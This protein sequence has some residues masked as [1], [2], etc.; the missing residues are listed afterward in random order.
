MKTKKKGAIILV[1][2]Q[3]EHVSLFTESEIRFSIK[4]YYFSL[5]LGHLQTE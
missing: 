4:I 1:T 3:Q 2:A 5:V